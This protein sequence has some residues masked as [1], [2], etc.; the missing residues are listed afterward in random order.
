MSVISPIQWLTTSP[1][2]PRDVIV[3]NK[4]LLSMLTRVYTSY[5]Q[6]MTGV[7]RQLEIAVVGLGTLLPLAVAPFQRNAERHDRMP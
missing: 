2:I 4:R 6:N 1:S 7:G 3:V 5:G